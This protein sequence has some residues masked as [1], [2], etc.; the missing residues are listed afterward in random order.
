ML[1]VAPERFAA[2][3][4]LNL[5]PK[6]RPNLFVVDEAHCVSFWG[7]D[8]RPEYMNLAE[9]RKALGSPVTMGLTA[10][11]T[12]QVRRD[13][14]EM[15]GLRSP[16][17][18][19]TGF[20]RPNL[21]YT[22]RR[23]ESEHEKDDALLRLL[24]AR[25][26]DGGIVYCSTRKAVENLAALLEDELAGRTVCAYH[27]GMEKQVRKHSQERFMSD[28]KSIAVATNAFGM[29]INKPNIR[30]VVHYN[31]PGSV[32]AYYQEAG[33]AG[34]DGDPA[35]CVLFYGTRDLKTQEFFIDKIGENNEALKP[36]EIERLQDH[37][38]S[39]L[40]SMWSYANK[41]RCRRRQILDYFGEATPI[42][43]CACDVCAGTVLHRKS[44]P[45]K[46]AFKP[47]ASSKPR[48][49]K[50]SRTA[51]ISL[52]TDPLTGDAEL[53]FERLK[54]VRRQLAD[55][56]QWPAFCVMHDSTLMEVARRSP[57]S[58][59]EFAAIK[60]IGDKK[61]VH[62]GPAFLKVLSEE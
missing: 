11:A 26:D 52:S 34:R 7:H 30:Y 22:A 55:K 37:S 23:L 36:H 33:R 27:A 54:R 3:S 61:A 59:R 50:K 10:T 32:E 21:S 5:L 6:L 12:P 18:H 29:G 40:N 17:V 8:F 2:P 31:L 51:K 20:D 35:A 4:F 43:K 41:P 44:A 48:S 60:G 49:K 13:I 1:Y 46:S 39:K 14:V 25:Q 38:R 15:L 47:V 24:G 58:I 57:N 45:P 16:K 9:V 53:R 62:F 28:P 19:V 56:L 42:A